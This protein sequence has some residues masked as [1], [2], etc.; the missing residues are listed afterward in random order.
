V[1]GAQGAIAKR[2]API[3]MHDMAEQTIAF[4]TSADGATNGPLRQRVDIIV[5]HSRQRRRHFIGL[6]AGG[7]IDRPI[8]CPRF[9]PP[10]DR[11]MNE[12][13]FGDQPRLRVRNVKA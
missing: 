10:Q 1:A 2:I 3:R 11:F 4:V 6:I 7:K 8:V 13:A 9:H 5:P 12:G